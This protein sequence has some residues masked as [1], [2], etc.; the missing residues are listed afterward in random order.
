MG[1]ALSVAKGLRHFEVFAACANDTRSVEALWHVLRRTTGSIRRLSVAPD[2][3]IP[4]LHDE[5]RKV[6][7]GDFEVVEPPPGYAPPTLKPGRR[8]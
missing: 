1:A 4:V 6:K 5:L 7:G 2:E 8:D 3:R